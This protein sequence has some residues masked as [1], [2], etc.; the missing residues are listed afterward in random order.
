MAF[1]SKKLAFVM[2]PFLAAPFIVG[3]LIYAV[4]KNKPKNPK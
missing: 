4:S 2:L 1:K 3:F